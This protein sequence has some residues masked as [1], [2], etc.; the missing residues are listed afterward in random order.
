MHYL[1]A[2]MLLW[3]FVTPLQ[4]K[5]LVS[6]LLDEIVDGKVELVSLTGNGNSS[7]ASLEGILV[8][9]TDRDKH[10]DIYLAQPIYMKNSGSGQD[11]VATQVLLGDGGYVTDGERSFLIL[12]PGALTKIFFVAYCADFERPNPSVTDSFTPWDIP[13]IIGIIAVN[14]NKYVKNNPSTDITVAAQLSFWLAQGV[15]SSEIREK[16]MFTSADEQ[17]ARRFLP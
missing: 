11:M 2:L 9:K 12:K 17:L 4:G 7:G 3:A 10:I 5:T 14:I 16:F 13:E 1:V 15:S 6:D 8:N